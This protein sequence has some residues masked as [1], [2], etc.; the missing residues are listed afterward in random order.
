[1]LPDLIREHFCFYLLEIR[2]YG[3]AEILTVKKFKEKIK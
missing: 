2:I 1:M 3:R